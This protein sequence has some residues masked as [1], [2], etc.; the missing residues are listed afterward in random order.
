MTIRVLHIIVGLDVGGAET[1]LKRLIESDPS[2]IHSTVV[3][4]LTSLGVLGE[5]LRAH[6]VRVHTLGM[7]SAFGIFIAI[8]RLVK[9]IRQYQ[10]EIVQT[11]MYHADLL[12]G[13]A[14]RL[15]RYGAVVWGIRSTAIPQGP[16]SPTFWL[17]RLCA[18]SSYLIPHK[19]IC[20]ARTA[21]EAHIKL[22]FAAQK[23][24]VIP[25]GYD[26]SVFDRHFNSRANARAEMGFED[27]GIVIGTVGRFDPLKDFENFVE[28]SS[29]LAAKRDDVKF[30][31]AGRN[32]EWSN[33]TLR[34]WIDSGGSVKKFSLFGEQSDVPYILSAM[35]VFCLS[36]VSEAF[37]NVLV[38]AMA[39]GLPCVVTRAGDAADIL[40]VNDFVVPVKDSDSL[41]DALKQM[42]DLDPEV[43]RELGDKGAKKV[44][45]EYGIENIRQKY[46][47]VYAET[48]MRIKR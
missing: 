33:P 29:K 12:G 22:G 46:E 47:K 32:I 28:A 42:C 48:V 43:R 25:N 4:S 18:I 11:W 8:W 39:M 10:P 36:S 14:A 31:M 38:E 3:V 1:M 23:M 13:L 30:L 15:S 24:T 7:T 37:P 45:E 9:L 26:F 44:R 19:I 16:L 41:S 21:K 40:G 20:C 17:V 34:K 5:S 27:N 35:D 2:T 6:G